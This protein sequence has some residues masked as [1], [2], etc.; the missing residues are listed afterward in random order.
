MNDRSRKNLL[1]MTRGSEELKV[2]WIITLYPWLFLGLF[3][4]YRRRVLAESGDA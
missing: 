2:C 4:I 1:L 3:T